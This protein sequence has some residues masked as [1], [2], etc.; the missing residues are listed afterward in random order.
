MLPVLFLLDQ[1]G[2]LTPQL[3]RL[4]G[5]TGTTDAE[6]MQLMSGA[7]EQMQGKDSCAMA[8]FRAYASAFERNVSA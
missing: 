7:R 6:M 2:I 4:F 5:Y 3:Q 8:I 1:Q